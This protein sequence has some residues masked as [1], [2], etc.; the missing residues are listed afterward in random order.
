MK[1]ADLFLEKEDD[2]KGL[3]SWSLSRMIKNLVLNLV[4]A[5]ALP[6]KCKTKS[7]FLN[8]KA[9][10]TIRA[11]SVTSLHGGDRHECHLWELSFSNILVKS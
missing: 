5:C 8:Q 6:F 7:S 11:T 4:Y 9:S 1:K 2:P 3:S 10:G